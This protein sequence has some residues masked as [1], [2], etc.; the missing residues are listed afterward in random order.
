M[1][2]VLVNENSLSAIAD[3]I[4]Q[5]AGTQDTYKPAEMAAAIAAIP[6]G[7]AEEAPKKDVNF[8]DPYGRR[9]YSY[10][11]D[12]IQAMDALPEAPTISGAEFDSWT[13]TLADLK[14]W[15][16]K[17]NVAAIFKSAES[18]VSILK[19]SIAK[20]QTV[21]FDFSAFGS[22]TISYGDGTT[23]EFVSGYNQTKPHEYAAGEYDCVF[24]GDVAFQEG[25]VYTEN[26]LKRGFASECLVGAIIGS[27]FT[28]Y[29]STFRG[30]AGL[31]YVMAAQSS[32]N[33]NFGGC[34]S[35]VYPG[36][37]KV[38]RCTNCDS[39]RHTHAGPA[40]DFDA[41]MVEE[42]YGSGPQFARVN[43]DANRNIPFMFTDVDIELTSASSS[44]LAY[45]RAKK[46][47]IT[48][49][50]S[51]T[52]YCP[53]VSQNEYL[54]ELEISGVY[55]N[56]SSYSMNG[57][58]SLHKLSLPSTLASINT[59]MFMNDG[60]FSL[61]IPAPVATIAASALS[62]LPLMKELH[63]KPTTPPAVANSNAFRNLPNTCK[64]YVPTG[65]L[66]AYTSAT[67]Y[68]SSANYTY[69]EED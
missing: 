29:T 33:F 1:A 34:R 59:G 23:D 60:L 62:D 68:P 50:E 30:Q 66:S 58:S 13:S 43:N 2:N 17:K 49:T 61:T 6:T 39:M 54:E 7:P 26:P 12:E 5:K 18:N 8:Y 63:F 3:A 10:T 28:L 25:F 42:L 35:L 64:I 52:G 36:V 65:C 24:S 22:G 40:S 9:I 67:N 41:Y 47:K 57:N 69:V 4:R 27:A 38:G 48:G 31:K 19:L 11:T 44:A 46:I 53:A 32:V 21:N 45:T 15:G 56:T 14:A 37:K 20:T 16:R 51:A 55:V